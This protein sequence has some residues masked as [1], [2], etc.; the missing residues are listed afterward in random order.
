MLRGRAWYDNSEANPAIPDPDSS[1]K[2]GKQSFEE[3]MFGFYDWIPDGPPQGR[4]R[5]PRTRT[6]NN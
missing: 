3:M 1:V 2:Y 6:D 5:S 4:I